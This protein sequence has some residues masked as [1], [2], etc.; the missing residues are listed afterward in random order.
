MSI[1][2]STV[3][4]GRVAGV[5]LLSLFSLFAAVGSGGCAATTDKAVISQ[6]NQ[7]QSNLAPAE[8]PD[9]QVNGYLDRIGKRIIAAAVEL[10][11]QHVGPKAHFDEGQSEEWMFQNVQFHLV[12]SE[13]LNAFTTGGNHV[14]IYNALLQL[15]QNQAQPA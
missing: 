14:Y 13:T 9:P 12:N 4:P 3:R 15:S 10:D 7:F 8:V 11:K 1:S 5:C 2:V 6:A